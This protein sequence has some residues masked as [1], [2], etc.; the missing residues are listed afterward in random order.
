MPQNS[1]TCVTKKERNQKKGDED[2]HQPSDVWVMISGVKLTY[3][4]R[5]ILLNQLGWLTDEH[6]DAAQHLIKELNPRVGGLNCIA[7]TTHCSRFALRHDPHHTIQ[8]HNTGAHWLT[9]SSISGEVVVYESLYRSLNESL[10]RQLVNIY[11]GLCNDD[12]SLNITVVLQQRQIGSSDCGLFCIA[13]AVAVANGID[14]ST[15]VWDQD[16]MRDHLHDCFER[17]KLEMFPH[18][19][20]QVPSTRSHYVVSIYCLCYRHIPGAQV[21]LCNTCKNWF[22]H[23]QSQTCINL[24]AKQVAALATNSPFIC[25]YCEKIAFQSPATAQL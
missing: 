5:D 20:K 24:S 10:K 11:K 12:G 1:K 16:R 17:R 7:A 18:K 13:N 21:V 22:H 14:P 2:G 8:C 9:S 19:V 25:E 15:V 3:E 23:G 4:L 6:I